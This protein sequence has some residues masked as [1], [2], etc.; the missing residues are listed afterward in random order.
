M[1]NLS[2]QY[3]QYVGLIYVQYSLN[4]KKGFVWKMF[5]LPLSVEIL[6]KDGNHYP[7]EIHVTFIF[8]QI[9]FS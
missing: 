6:K 7:T 3:V 9:Y 5:K 2:S 1:Q 4:Q 8:K